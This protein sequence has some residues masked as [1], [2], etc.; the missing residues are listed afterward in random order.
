MCAASGCCFDGVCL[1]AE[2]ACHDPSVHAPTPLPSTRA[3]TQAL[4]D[5]HHFV[6]ANPEP[7]VETTLGSASTTFRAFILRGL[8]K[9]T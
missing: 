8:H 6:V 9:V 4:V 1:V 7:D 2:Q 3:R 5:L